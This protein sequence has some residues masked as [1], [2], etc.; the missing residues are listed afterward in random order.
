M[1]ALNVAAAFGGE[2]ERRRRKELGLSRKSLVCLCSQSLTDID[3]TYSL[4]NL[5]GSKTAPTTINATG[6]KG[7]GTSKVDL[8]SKLGSSQMNDDLEDLNNSKKSI[9]RFV[10]P[11]MDPLMKPGRG[12]NSTLEGDVEPDL[13]NDDEEEEG[14][15]VDENVNDEDD[16]MKTMRERMNERREGKPQ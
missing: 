2:F 1:R 6:L 16:I 7:L 3:K 12:I 9:K 11:P 14:R 13:E 10:L 15:G 5:S 8:K 4:S